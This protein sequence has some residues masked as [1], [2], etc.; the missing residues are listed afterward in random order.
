M[1]DINERIRGLRKALGLNQTELGERIGMTHGGVADI[2]RGKT[3]TVND[4][5]VKLIVSE[6]GISEKWLRTGEGTMYSD[7]K[8]AEI[9]NARL[10]SEGDPFLSECI[11]L[12]CQLSPAKL[13][14]FK[15]FI[16]DLVDSARAA[17]DAETQSQEAA[18][19][20]PLRIPDPE[21]DRRPDGESDPA[22]EVEADA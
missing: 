14:L 20:Q 22:D 4:R 19:A 18:E 2:E 15:E 10:N 17:Q 5:I 6:F 9:L 13:Q 7:S 16:F 8:R 12:L 1:S 11:T 21:R 3:K